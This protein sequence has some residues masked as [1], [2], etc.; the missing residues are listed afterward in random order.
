MPELYPEMWK[1]RVE[2]LLS[3]TD[4]APWLDGIEEE[5]TQIIEVGSGTATEKNLIHIALEDFDVNVL[6]NNSSYPLDT[7]SFTD[8]S[9]VVSLD[10]WETEVTTLTD[11]QVMG[12]S[13]KRIDSA[14][15]RHRV[16]ISENKFARAIWALAPAAEDADNPVLKTTGELKDGR[17]LMVYADLIALQRACNK[18]KMPKNSRRLVL[19]ADHYSDLLL[20]EKFLKEINNIK[21]G[22][23]APKIAGFF[24]Y[25]YDDNPYFEDVA[26]TLTKTAD[27]AVITP[28]THFQASVL[29]CAVNVTKKTGKT[30]Q[31]YSPASA[32]PKNPVNELNYRHYFIT[33][34]KRQKY[35]D[36]IID[37]DA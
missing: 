2:K 13:Y 23:V 30:K 32:T 20:D 24:I 19:N 37:A 15:S 14:T 35:M 27:G 6:R 18:A 29:F 21:E 25:Q 7:Q 10:K 34:P 9:V 8:D 31:Y 11:D 33:V 3:T 22:Q 16:A 36:A 1:R 26:G 4:T 17:R 12:A 28:G 5:E